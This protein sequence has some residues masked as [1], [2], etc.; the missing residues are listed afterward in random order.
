MAPSLVY[1]TAPWARMKLMMAAW[2]PHPAPSYWSSLKSPVLLLCQSPELVNWDHWKSFTEI[3]PVAQWLRLCASNSECMGSIPD[4]GTQIPYTMVHSQKTK[5]FKKKK[6][7]YLLQIN[8]LKATLQQCEMGEVFAK[9]ELPHLTFL[10][11]Y[12]SSV[13]HLA[14]TQA[15]QT[16]FHLLF[17]TILAFLVHLSHFKISYSWPSQFNHQIYMLSHLIQYINPQRI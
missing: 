14:L 2:Y 15:L 7:L 17:H 6:K 8:S 4:Q 9:Q 16:S 12:P 13:S 11:I 10:Y 3:S 1:G 5:I